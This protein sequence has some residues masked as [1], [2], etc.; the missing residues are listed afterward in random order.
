MICAAL[1]TNE[2]ISSLQTRLAIESIHGGNASVLDIF[3]RL[4]P[5]T[6]DVLRSYIAPISNFVSSENKE[7]I[8]S[9]EYRETIKR[10]KVIP[11]AAYQDTLIQ[12]PEGFVGDLGKYLSVL[13][14][15]HTELVSKAN[16][17]VLGYTDELSIFLNNVDYRKSIK[18]HESFY[19]KIRSERNQFSKELAAFFKKDGNQSRVKLGS[20]INRFGDLDDIFNSAEKLEVLHRSSS[21][22]D[23]LATVNLS[24]SLLDLIKDKLNNDK[25]MVISG[26]MAKHISQGAYEVASYVELVSLVCF[27]IEVALTSVQNLSKQFN[28]ITG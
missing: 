5:K 21:L 13:V 20:V 3:S 8:K 28:S 19:L 27:N 9:S 16:A 1:E 7:T 18:D 12:V 6:T 11:F 2:T 4:I 22:S 14:K 15:I 24:V 26:Q 23:L 10:V 25:E 17:A